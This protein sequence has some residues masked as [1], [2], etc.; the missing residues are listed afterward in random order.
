MLNAAVRYGIPMLALFGAGPLAGY[1]TASLR[2]PDA[3]KGAS[4]LITA[5]PMQGIIAGVVAM[6]LALGVGAL[7]ARLV[8]R[9]AGMFSAGLVLAWAAMN[10]GRVDTILGRTQ[11]GA[12]LQTI[13]LE[14]VLV[15]AMG[16]AVVLVIFMI[17]E[18]HLGTK[19][20]PHQHVLPPEPTKLLDA[21][22]PIALAAAAV[23]GAVSCWVIAQSTLKGQTFAAAT[24]AG[25]FAAAAGRVAS[26]RVSPAIF[27]AGIAI[28]AS[29]SPAL[30]TVVH[31]GSDGVLRAAIAGRLFA[32]ARPLP[33]DWLA[34]AFL[35]VPIGLTWAGSMLEKHAPKRS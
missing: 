9:R 15:G 24:I 1:L 13:A 33:L 31:S 27:V 10:T 2:T 12:S 4:L 29:V 28:L 26:Q 11:S 6:G 22:A 3:G 20:A 7:G 17:P 25:V 14:G 5:T 21:T 32:L 34:G 30:A 18:R 8:G 19:A 23:A 16:L 35:G